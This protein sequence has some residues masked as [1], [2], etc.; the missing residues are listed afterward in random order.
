MNRYRKLRNVILILG[1]ICCLMGGNAAVY[2]AASSL[3]AIEKPDGWKSGAT[4]IQITVDSNE[5]VTISKIEAKVGDQDGWMDVTQSKSVT[6]DQNCTVYVKVTDNNGNIYEQNRNIRCFDNERPTLTASLTDGVLYVTGKDDISGIASIS[7][8]DASFTELEEGS[9]KIQLTQNELNTE[10]ITIQATDFAGNT[11][12]VYSMPNPYY[13]WAQEQANQAGDGLTTSSSTTG[14]DKEVQAPLPQN[15]EPSK[16][17][18][19]TGTVID[20]SS[21]Q[22]EDSETA[23]TS[24]AQAPSTKKDG[25]EFYSIVT[26]G[27]KTFYLVVDNA[28]TDNNVYFLT[29]V[30]EQDLLNFTLSDTV[31]LPKTGT[32]IATPEEPPQV[33]ESEEPSTETEQMEPEPQMPENQSGAAVYLI[34]GLVMVLV[35]I[36]GYYFKIY[37]PKHEIEIEEDEE[38]E[39]MP[40]EEETVYEDIPEESEIVDD[41]EE[42]EQGE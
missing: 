5:G 40:E 22:E 23:D 15:A 30:D 24:S 35:F 17:T 14:T 39:E 19:A 18:D 9:L 29:E 42:E 36:G 38:D 3:I 16:P 34:V 7:V 33:Q 37:K 21:T 26:K 1:M 41:E 31:T 13:A 10:K 12:D 28:R 2:A 11:S 4:S 27:G 25:K 32:I 6:I 8:N 20:R